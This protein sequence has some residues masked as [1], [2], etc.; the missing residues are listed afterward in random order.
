[1]T[2]SSSAK[3]SAPQAPSFAIV[4]DDLVR[5]VDF[6]LQTRVTTVVAPPGYGKSVLL[7]QWAATYP[8]RRVAWLRLEA[9]DSNATEFARSL[10]SSIQCL[11]PD[12]GAAAL[13]RVGVGGDVVGE[14]FSRT[15]LDELAMLP[16]LIF[17]LDD[18][19]AIR[20]G[21]LLD[22]IAT[23][24]SNSP[25]NL[26][27]VLASRSDPGIGLHRLRVRGDLTEFRRDDL[28]IRAPDA[29][30]LL[31][32]VAKVELGP[33][34]VDVLV[35]RTE[36]WPAGLQLAALSLRGRDDP[37]AFVTT[38]SGDD[39]H[40]AEYL[41]DEV[42]A[43]QT[44]D[45]R[46]FLAESSVLDVMAGQQCD[47]ILGRTD[48]QR[49]LESLDRNGLMVVRLD[50]NRGWFRY[51]PLLRDLLRFELRA[52]NRARETELLDRAATWHED[53]GDVEFAAQYLADAQDW[54]ALIA[55]THRYGR[56]MFE[57]G[58]GAVLLDW[59]SRMPVDLRQSRNDLS[60]AWALVHA[61]VGRTLAA[62][63]ELT[64]L[65]ESGPMSPW[66]EAE[67][68]TLR[69]QMVQTHLAPERAI[70]AG[71]RA[72]D[73]LTRIHLDEPV[74]DALGVGAP[75]FIE[76]MAHIAIGRAHYFLNDP[77][78][79]RISFANAIDDVE[80]VNRI[81]LMQG[82]GA[83]AFVEARLG[84]LNTALALATRST[85]MGD[86]ESLASHPS[87]AEAYLAIA[88]VWRDRNELE[89]AELALD[90][91]HHRIRRNRRYALLS[92]WVAESALLA[93]A[94]DR[95]NDGLELIANHRIEGGPPPPPLPAARL[96]ALE[97]RLLVASGELS[98]ATQ[99]LSEFDGLHNT[100]VA[101][102]QVALAVA[103]RDVP[104]ARKA[105]DAF[106]SEVGRRN[107]IHR[108]MWQAIVDDLD[109]DHRAAR[110]SMTSAVE[111]A[112]DQQMVRV[113]L[114]AG[115]DAMR[116]LRGLYHHE[117]T[118][119]LRLVVDQHVAPAPPQAQVR[120]LVE[121]LSDR[122]IVVLRYLPSRLSN[123]EIARNLY[124]SVNTLKT[125]LKH[126]Y[127]KLDVTNRSEAIAKAESLGLL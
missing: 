84:E 49:M 104:A 13:E 118:P 100:D 88:S 62:E 16:D 117:P 80:G 19:E 21:A 76:E 14:D 30:E 50:D 1:M 66:E 46:E 23:M 111:A 74:P 28:A 38:F 6:G 42:L 44:A 47:D 92:M 96:A 45:V 48:S 77:E 57:R 10:V 113:L 12:V 123:P 54:D 39:R 37:D 94:R 83:L 27:F 105:L 95:P 29:D 64:R 11:Y 24:V 51:H 121:Q 75:T 91:A 115:S 36:G 63:E 107:R 55:L 2:I 15:L 125:H 60:L 41:T 67:A 127:R 5:R 22:E 40:V 78:A 71:Q 86:D 33:D 79:A 73:C 122:E 82:L 34:A 112:E 52:T 31:R 68:E 116:L 4:R 59:M 85:D 114:D 35:R 99:I 25:P 81:A 26:R 97:A 69:A 8:D 108:G 124:I 70:D 110:A 3:L 65:R 109:G 102:A 7:A 18:V 120:G 106:P 126:I 98:R 93:L 53:H 43:R 56:S 58:Q 72:L 9:T 17:V 32:R 89:Q 20:N 61:W 119:F 90:E 103:R 87:M 101:V